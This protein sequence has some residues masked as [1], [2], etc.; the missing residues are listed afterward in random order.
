MW[1]FGTQVQIAHVV[2]PIYLRW[3]THVEQPSPAPYLSGGKVTFAL[4]EQV[5]LDVPR[6]VRA[7][8]F[9]IDP[10]DIGLDLPRPLEVPRVGVHR[11]LRRWP[12]NTNG[13]VVGNTFRIEGEYCEGYSSGSSYF[14]EAE[15][16]PASLAPSRQ[17][18]VVQVALNSGPDRATVALVIEPDI[19]EV[20]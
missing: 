4:T 3:E 11:R 20:V 13:V 9:T 14:G 1:R 16:E 19:E 18:K 6:L 2:R 5:E 12:C 10:F 15:Y 7:D 8:R 17:V